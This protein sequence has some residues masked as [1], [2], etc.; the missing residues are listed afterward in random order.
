MSTPETTEPSQEQPVDALEAPTTEPAQEAEPETTATPEADP[1]IRRVRSEAARYRTQLRESEERVKALEREKMS[2]TERVQAERDEAVAELARVREQAQTEALTSAA[3]R[4]GAQMGLNDPDD[5][6]RLINAGA[7]TY[8]PETGQPNNIPD[9]VT[10]LITEKPYLVKTPQQPRRQD[11]GLVPGGQQTGQHPVPQREETLAE[12]RARLAGGD[13]P[14]GGDGLALHNIAARGGGVWM[15][16][17][18]LLTGEREPD[19]SA[20]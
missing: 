6:I 9:L 20:A 14:G 13:R 17:K 10:A 1:E 2:E 18:N 3:V 7:I 16:G 15:G 5:A 19:G 4:V 12:R 11:A 8:D